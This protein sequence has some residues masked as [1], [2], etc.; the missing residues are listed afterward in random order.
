M[1]LSGIGLI[2]LYVVLVPFTGFFFATAV[3]LFAFPLVG[4]FKRP[5]IAAAISAAGTLV[6]A[7]VFLKIA[8][9]SL[10]LGVGPFQAL[11][12]GLMRLLGVT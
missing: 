10:P 9:I 8:Y 12:I 2:S 5:G 6:L 7:V 11:S 3:F 1:L 4:G